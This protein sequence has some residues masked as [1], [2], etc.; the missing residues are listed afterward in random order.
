MPLSLMSVVRYEE[1]LSATGRS[2][3]LLSECGVLLFVI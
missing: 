2:L 3:V 1:K